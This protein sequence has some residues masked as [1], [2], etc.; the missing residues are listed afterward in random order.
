[1]RILCF[2]GFSAAGKKTAI[3]RIL[4]GDVA[5][6]RR[7]GVV[8][9]MYATGY[10]FGP[11]CRER[12]AQ[13]ATVLV[14]WQ[15]AEHPKLTQLREWFPDAEHRVFFLLRH[16][17]AHLVSHRRKYAGVKYSHDDL[18]LRTL[19][20]LTRYFLDV[21]VQLVSLPEEAPTS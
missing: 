2:A 14:Q 7:F 12:C 5:L 4:G 3:R 15:C 6:C 10:A 21:P 13:A 8:P 17:D 9:P 1:M 20:I 16:W 18:Q 19:A 11:F